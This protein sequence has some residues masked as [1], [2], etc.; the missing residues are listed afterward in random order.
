MN[1]VNVLM[2]EDNRGDVVLVEEAILAA[3]LDY[4]VAVVRDG[5]AAMDYLRR[6][7]THAGAPHPDLI[8][9]DLKLPRKSGRQVLAELDADSA[10]RH[11]PVAILSSSRSELGLARI[12]RP[13]NHADFAKPSTFSGY[14]E[15]L[16]AIAAFH[17]STLTC[18]PG[19][20]HETS[21]G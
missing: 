19:D 10:L 14:V 6:Q 21:P 13:P 15:L 1:S 2:V 8:L 18:S 20:T 4:R 12:G 5:V 17:Q 16:Q 7:G 9:L 3:G 11:I